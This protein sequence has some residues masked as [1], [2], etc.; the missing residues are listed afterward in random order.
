MVGFLIYHIIARIIIKQHTFIII[1]ATSTYKCLS[2]ISED[3]IKKIKASSPGGIILPGI[4]E[5]NNDPQ[6]E[7]FESNLQGR[8]FYYLK[9]RATNGHWI[10]VAALNKWT[11]RDGVFMPVNSFIYDGDHLVIAKQI[12]GKRLVVSNERVVTY[13]NYKGGKKLDTP[14]ANGCVY[15]ATLENID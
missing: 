1:M 13:T 4:Y 9:V 7:V 12:S 6:I 2:Q 3:E 11:V 14:W 8:R 15:R 10:R 5:F